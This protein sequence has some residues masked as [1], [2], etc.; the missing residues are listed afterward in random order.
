MLATDIATDFGGRSIK[1][2][3]VNKMNIF[4]FSVTDDGVVYSCNRQIKIGA[5]VIFMFA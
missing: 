5:K 2:Y 4:K 1:F 3:W